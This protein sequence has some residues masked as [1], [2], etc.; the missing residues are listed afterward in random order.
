LIANAV[1]ATSAGKGKL[2]KR[3]KTNY[4]A[5][6]Q[7]RL[8]LLTLDGRSFPED[9]SDSHIITA[10]LDKSYIAASDKSVVIDFIN[11]FVVGEN[12]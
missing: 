8:P 1:A 6:M 5:R 11:N 10:C 4:I 12:L 3:E 7:N 2:L 9:R